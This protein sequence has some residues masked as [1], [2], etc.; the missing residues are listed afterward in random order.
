MS[1][2]IRDRENVWHRRLKLIYL[3]PLCLL[4]WPVLIVIEGMHEVGWQ[5]LND[6]ATA[7]KRGR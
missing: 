6:I 2:W 3:A 4:A 1:F 7:W 5:P